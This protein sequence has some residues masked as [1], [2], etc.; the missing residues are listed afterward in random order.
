MLIENVRISFPNIFRA[1]SFKPDQEPKFSATFI[2]AKDHPQIKAIKKA[3]QQA[4]VDK[5]GEKA[6]GMLKQIAAS[7]KM[8]LRDGD[9]KANMDGFG[10]GVLF[11]NASN[12]KRP[13]IYD[14]D[15]TPLVEEDGRPYAGCYVNALVDFWAQ[16]NQYGKRINA[17]LSGVQFV[18]DGEAF[19]GGGRVA[20]ADD[21]AEVEVD[22]D[23][24]AMA[25]DFLG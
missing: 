5:W 9:E 8:C 15:R 11:F 12:T 4:A 25:D 1:S 22:E 16:D 18:R 7:G 3:M 19:G 24:L 23:E 21:F 6:A 17:S 2:V 10:E 14:R 20:S 13:G